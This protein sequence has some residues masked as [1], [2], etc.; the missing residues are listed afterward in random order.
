MSCYFRVITQVRSQRVYA[1]NMIRMHVSQ[2]Y[3][4]HA[5]AFGNLLLDTLGEDLLLVFVRRAGID[6]E[7]LV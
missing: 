7:K 6:D 3:F 5:S 1:S 2:N 4:A